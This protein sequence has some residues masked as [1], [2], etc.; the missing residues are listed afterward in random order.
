VSDKK[1]RQFVTEV[2]DACDRYL[3]ARGEAPSLKPV[4]RDSV[5]EHPHFKKPAKVKGNPIC[6]CGHMLSVHKEP[7]DNAEGQ[8]QNI[9]RGCEADGSKIGCPEFVAKRTLKVDPKS[10]GASRDLP[11]G[12][13][14][15]LTPIHR[16]ILTLL[17]AKPGLTAEKISIYTVYTRSGTFNMALADLREMGLIEGSPHARLTEAGGEVAGVG[18]YL[19]PAALRSAWAMKLKA[20]SAKRMID[21]L[22]RGPLTVS[23]LADACHYTQSG[24]FNQMLAKLR[25][26][27][28]IERGSPVKLC[29]ELS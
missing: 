25:R 16:S 10:N 6:R 26:M 23:Q 5:H 20:E 21:A 2:R 22:V 11:V 29:K 28:L 1:F 7:Q 17:A 19:S 8:P 27:G 13:V 12:S 9:C 3:D 4:T 15:E 24:T 18:V 14:D